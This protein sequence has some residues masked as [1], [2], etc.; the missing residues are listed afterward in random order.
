MG[1][2]G[3]FALQAL[4]VV[5]FVPSSG[6]LPLRASDFRWFNSDPPG[7]VTSGPTA[8][9]LPVPGQTRTDG[10]LAVDDAVSQLA[11]DLGELDFT[12]TF[13]NG[14]AAQGRPSAFADEMVVFAT[15][16]DVTYHGFEFGI[17]LGLTDGIVYAYWQ[18]PDP[19][20]GVV[21]HEQPLFANDGRAHGYALLLSGAALS[22]S[23]DGKRLLEALYPVLP[24]RSFFVVTTAHRESSGW[25]VE[26]LALSVA[27]VTVRQ[28]LL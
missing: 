11:Y 23:V 28:P 3:L 9:V 22:F 8:W 1:A 14:T 19:A 17:R 25:E 2:V 24:P 15:T 4:L 12:A 20:G 5:T 27:N 6:P 10:K 26:G 7:P 18:Y 13:L 16:D 21:F